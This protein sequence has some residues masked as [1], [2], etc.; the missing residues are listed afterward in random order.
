MRLL[1]HLTLL[2]LLA[3]WSHAGEVVLVFTNDVHGRH[4][5][6]D[7]MG[8][9]RSG[10]APALA[11]RLAELRAGLAPDQELVLVDSGD[12]LFGE[13]RAAQ[14]KGVPAIRVMN[15]LGYDAVGL[16]NHEFDLGWGTLAARAHE[17]RFPFLAANVFHRDRVAPPGVHPSRLL[18][19]AK[20]GLRLGLVGI[21]REAAVATGPNSRNRGLR[22]GDQAEAVTREV[23]RLRGQGADVVVVLTHQGLRADEAML[24]ECPC[25]DVDLV[26]GGHVPSERVDTTHA[27]ARIL[28][29]AAEGLEF[30]VV[31]LRPGVPATQAPVEWIPWATLPAPAGELDALLEPYDTPEPVLAEVPTRWTLERTGEWVLT[32]MTALA[33]AHGFAPAVTLLNR[34]ALRAALARGPVTPATLRRI[35]P[36]DNHLVELELSARQL[37]Q[38]VAEGQAREGHAGLLVQGE[39]PERGRVKVLV[40]DYLAEGGDGFDA[41][42]QARRRKVLAST[43]RDAMRESLPGAVAEEAP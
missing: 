26:I 38:V 41:L 31:R 19:L 11:A 20:A 39:L 36:F 40:N 1:L 42:G 10:G 30:G 23:D 28:Q 7:L 15:A 13:G 9:E 24:D 27:G 33:R 3:G 6:R 37:R 32:A 8:S 17:A 34:G 29:A 14:L 5:P 35:A 16:G 2:L 22:F 21:T 12:F 18:V 43:V 4:Q 25:G